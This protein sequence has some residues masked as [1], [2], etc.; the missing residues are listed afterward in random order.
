MGLLGA[1]EMNKYWTRVRSNFTV[2][3]VA[4]IIILLMTAA[5]IAILL[6]VR[7]YELENI[8]VRAVTAAEVE[9]CA[10]MPR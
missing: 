9:V 8:Q 1:Y 7:N 2:F 6:A 3:G 4:T 10:E 5:A